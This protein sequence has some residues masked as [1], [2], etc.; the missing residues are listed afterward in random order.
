MRRELNTEEFIKLATEQADQPLEEAQ[1]YQT[2]STFNKALN[3]ED[4][5][6]EQGEKIIDLAWKFD[7]FDPIFYSQL[8]HIYARNRDIQGVL[9]VAERAVQGGF[10][11]N[12]QIYTSIMYAYFQ[13][14]KFDKVLEA[15][16]NMQKDGYRPEHPAYLM[17]VSSA[18]RTNNEALLQEVL[19]QMAVDGFTL[20]DKFMEACSQPPRSY[21]NASAAQQQPSMN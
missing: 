17:A 9:S 18:K 2:T 14:N 3:K 1:L 6:P 13:N 5:T 12:D 21:V 20:P 16:D 10:P 15:Y 19:L 7:Y 8:A 11:V 4:V